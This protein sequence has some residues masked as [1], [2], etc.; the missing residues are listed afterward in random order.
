ME[1][2]VTRSAFNSGK[3][4]V[5]II[6]DLFIDLNYMVYIFQ[7]DYTHGSFKGTI[8]AENGKFV[9]NAKSISIF[10]ERDPA[11]I[12]QGDDGAECVV[13]SAGV[14]TVLEKVGSPEGQSQEG[15]HLYPFCGCPHVCDGCEP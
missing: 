9:I 6:N 8:K 15:H 14:F 10:Q 3:V 12:K 4:D 7:Y 2:L 13:E 1:S 11:N 5:V